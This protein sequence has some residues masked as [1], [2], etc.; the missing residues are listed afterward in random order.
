M[1]VGAA[2]QKFDLFGFDSLRMPVWL[3]QRQAAKIKGRTDADGTLTLVLRDAGT[4]ALHALCVVQDVPS[5]CCGIPPTS[6]GVLGTAG[7]SIRLTDIGARAV[8][9]LTRWKACYLDV[10]GLV[11]G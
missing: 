8:R 5:R 9:I 10:G 6:L 11:H 3:A 1:T 4:P 7:N 2:A